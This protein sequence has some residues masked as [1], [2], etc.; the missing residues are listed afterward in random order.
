MKLSLCAAE[1]DSGRTV[2]FAF[3]DVESLSAQADRGGAVAGQ[4][5]PQELLPPLPSLLIE[6][7]RGGGLSSR[8]DEF[9]AGLL[10]AD[11]VG[12]R[13]D[14]GV[15]AAAGFDEGAG[16]IGPTSQ[17][18]CESATELFD[19]IGVPVGLGELGVDVGVSRKGLGL[20]GYGTLQAASQD[21]KCRKFWRHVRQALDTIA[22][23]FTGAFRHAR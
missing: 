19:G 23:I 10:E 22:A 2:S 12:D 1:K 14:G 18:R 17:Q 7:P 11:R 4:E 8:L 15:F 9:G 16:F 13:A 20:H 5:G 3:Y 21:Y 6:L